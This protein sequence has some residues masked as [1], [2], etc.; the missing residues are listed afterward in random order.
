MLSFLEFILESAKMKVQ[1]FYS[2]RFRQFLTE[3]VKSKKPGFE[4]ANFILHAE[5]SNQ[6]ED[7]ITFIDM[8]DSNDKVS[9]IQLNRVKRMYD[10]QKKEIEEQ[11]KNVFFSF[12]Q[13]IEGKALSEESSPWKNQR[14]DLYIGRFV[15]RVSEKAKQKLEP[16]EIEKF[17]NTYKSKFDSFKSGESRFEEVSGEVIKHWYNKNNYETILGQLGNSCMRNPS[18]KN[19]FNIYTQNPEV[20]SLLILKSEVDLDKICGRALVWKLS[21]G[22]TY[23]DRVYTVRDSDFQLYEDYAKKRNWLLEEDMD[24]RDFSKMIVNLKHWKFEQYPYMDT[25]KCLNVNEGYLTSDEDKWPGPGFWKLES[26]SGGYGG[27]N[28]VWSEYQDEYIDR[29]YAVQTLRGDWIHEDRAIY[30]EYKDGYATQDEEVVTCNFDGLSYYLDD[31]YHSD[32][33][34]DYIYVEDA[35]EITTNADGDTDYIHKDMDEIALTLELDGEEVKTLPWLTML[36]PIDGKYYFK[37]AMID[38]QRLVYHIIKSQELIPWEEV[39]KQILESD[40]KLE[41]IELP[42][43]EYKFNSLTTYKNSQKMNVLRSIKREEI[44]NIIKCLL[45][46]SPDK[47][48][49]R[50]SGEPLVTKGHRVF[51]TN[52]LERYKNNPVLNGLLSEDFLKLL[53]GNWYW[54]EYVGKAAVQLSDYFISDVL[55]DPRAIATWYS[56]KMPH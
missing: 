56:I 54:Q 39:V 43:G 47:S 33:M 41:E 28:L 37:D 26:T 30:L 1:Y 2:V 16:T 3:I 50:P 38:N 15:N 46:I 34:D 19:F 13:W 24:Y 52:L 14:T 27:D 42:P 53:N 20:C 18:C 21:D 31:T 4:V 36:N 5:Q 8:T 17:V 51:N 40:V 23:L 44:T 29:D 7:D 12:E 55:K 32:I 22:R 48:E 6:V 35:I 45:I 49:R 11:G 9:F 10:L 25:F